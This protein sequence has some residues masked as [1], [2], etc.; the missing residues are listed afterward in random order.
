MEAIASNLEI[1]FRTA[2]NQYQQ[3]LNSTPTW[4]N[5]LAT[6]FPS[7]TRQNVFAWMD[8]IPILRKW[9]GERVVNAAA[10]HSRT[11]T[12]LPFELT[13]ELDKFDIEDDQLGLFTFG[14]Q[15]MGMQA[16]KWPDQQIAKWLTTTTTG[17]GNEGASI[18]NS[19]DGVPQFSTAHPLLGGDVV[20]QANGGQ[21]GNL[22]TSGTQS[23]LAVSTALNFD[24]YVAARTTMMSWLGADGQP[25]NINP[26]LLVV[27]PALESTAR[28]ILNSDYLPSTSGQGF[29]TAPGQATMTNTYKG[30]AQLLVVPELATK[31]A[32]W[33][34]FDTTKVVKPFIWMLR[35][36]PIFTARTAPT[37][38]VVFDTHK[39]KY[40]IEARG[41]ALE[42]LWFLSYA[43]T[44][45]ASY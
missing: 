6:P 4:Y 14:V 12:N 27:P 10:T 20:G 38:P 15:N 21:G 2:S 29:T 18:T 23:N 7:A 32:N 19:F 26:N 45:N 42:S 24:N 40:G 17:Q 3:L 30:S 36:A 34:L 43:G 31:P 22:N 25:L 39:F 9:V 33:Y 11:A 28:A 8:R 44:S 37:D 35:T 1:V 16:A 5:Q 41:T 13:L